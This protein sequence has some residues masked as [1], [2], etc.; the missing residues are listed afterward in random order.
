MII[1]VNQKN[2]KRSLTLVERIVSKNLTLPVLQNIVLKTENGRLKISSTNLEIGMNSWI[3]AKIEEEGEIA[4]PAKVFSDFIDN[5]Q[6]EKITINSK[7]HVISINSDSYKTKIIGFSAK[8][9]P[10]IPRVKENSFIKIPSQEFLEIL[11]TVIDSVSLSE[12]R[13][14]LSGILI[15]FSAD[16]I[17]GAATD[18]FRLAEKVLNI[19]NS[20]PE[21]SIILPRVTAQELIRILPGLE[22][23]SISISDNQIFFVSED[24]E[25]VSRLID[26]SYP[27]YKKVIPERRISRVLVKKEEIEKSVRL[28]GVFS[29]HISD[30]KING[31]SEGLRIA[32]KNTDK[33]EAS[34]W[35]SSAIVKD[36]PFEVMVN[37][38]YLMDGLKIIPTENIVLEFT[39]EGNPLIIRPEERKDIT[40]L[41]M[42]LR[43]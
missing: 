31:E 10:I 16:K 4:V 13:P 12:S 43:N 39:G 18:S 22:N 38:R 34:S 23:I 37:Y 36:E 17:E 21:Q 9:F 29:S 1:T 30:I 32:A 35:I 42:P 15:N 24:L 27:D 41:I 2:L 6:D 14:E 7:E 25:I 8:D 40:Y 28:A 19:K 5:I 3:G 33:G 11:L 20:K 26:G